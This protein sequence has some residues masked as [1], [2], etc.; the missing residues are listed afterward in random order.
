MN[1]AT[2]KE[3]FMTT[4]ELAETLGVSNMAIMRVLE[5]T[6]NLNGSVKVENGKQTYFNEQQ[7]TLIKHTPPSQK[8]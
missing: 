4:K 8:T 7:A 5:K 6:N 1:E 3:I 2:T